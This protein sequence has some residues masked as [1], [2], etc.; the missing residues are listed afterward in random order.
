MDQNTATCAIAVMAK[1]PRPGRCKTRLSP[2]LTPVQAAALSAA[3]LRDITENI[4][5]AGRLTKIH[6][7]IAYAPLGLEAL[8]DGHLAPG[9]G[10]VLAD[11]SPEMPE[12]VTGFG[13][14]LLHAVQSLLA[15]G[16]GSACVLNSDSP[17][18]P[19]AILTRT[20]KLLAKPGDRAVL[21]PADDGGYYLLGVKTAHA[22]LFEDIAWSTADV[23]AQ[24]RQ[25][26]AEIG[27]ELVEL[28]IWYDVDD[29]A[30]LDRL[31][32]SLGDD[33]AV[34]GGASAPFSAPAT[35]ACLAAIGFAPAASAKK[36]A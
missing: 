18:L 19:T 28:P 11:G 1:A 29:A 25:R 10:L 23:A 30:S 6:G 12:K 36:R 3:F 22:H 16:Y 8:F 32:D 15:E 9:T 20:A 35:A 2:P 33:I 27:L 7:C 17:T 24:T 13:R 31:I 4:V 5:A 34:R 21:G 26:A 14:C